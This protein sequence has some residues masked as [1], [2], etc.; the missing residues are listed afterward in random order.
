MEGTAT[1]EAER[2]SGACNIAS[3]SVDAA[4]ASIP[5]LKRRCLI[6]ANELR[7]K[8]AKELV[9]FYEMQ[10]KYLEDTDPKEVHAKF[11]DV[12][13]DLE[14][15][16]ADDIICA[17]AD[18]TLE[19]SERNPE[20]QSRYTTNMQKQIFKQN[21]ATEFDKSNGDGRML[22]PILWLK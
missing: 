11:A 17:N 22:E 1:L 6:G 15:E 2:A 9:G 3:A 5:E 19:Q 4:D 7:L 18:Y 13:V 8:R 16:G 20:L 14:A 21:S 12:G 10:S